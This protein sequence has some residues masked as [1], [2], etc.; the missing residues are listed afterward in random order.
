ML[1]ARELK[2]KVVCEELVEVRK[3]KACYDEVIRQNTKDADRIC[4]EAEEKHDFT[5]LSQ[6]NS[7]RNANVEKQKQIDELKKLEADLILRRDSIV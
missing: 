2:R 5:L 1:N 4:M 3:K 6:A 7:I